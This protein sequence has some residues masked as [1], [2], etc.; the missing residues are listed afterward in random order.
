LFEKVTRNRGGRGLAS[1]QTEKLQGREKGFDRQP[2]NF[3]GVDFGECKEISRGQGGGTGLG[4]GSAVPNHKTRSVEKDKRKVAGQ[5]REKGGKEEIPANEK[6]FAVG[7]GRASGYHGGKKQGAHFRVF[8]NNIRWIDAEVIKKWRGKG[9]LFQGK[10][11]V[12]S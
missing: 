4:I 5:L 8:T 11:E 7:K 6:E 3:R 12:Q 9:E 2:R 10:D 1:F